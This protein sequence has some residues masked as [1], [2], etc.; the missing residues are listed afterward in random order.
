M[1]M[2]TNQHPQTFV[3]FETDPVAA[4]DLDGI[5][6]AAFAHAECSV[7]KDP[8]QAATFLSTN[9]APTGVLVK[10][11]GASQTLLPILKDCAA[12]GSRIVFLGQAVAVDFPATF[13]DTPF[14]S[15]MIVSS[16]TPQST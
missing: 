15:R 4:L 12:Q 1:N 7:F 2:K 5:V 9:P 16:L 10:S 14:T 8:R 6:A 11:G 13:I 3:I